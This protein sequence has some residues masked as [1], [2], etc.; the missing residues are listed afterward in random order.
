MSTI[1]AS[2]A[3]N[4][5]SVNGQSVGGALKLDGSYDPAL[6]VAGLDEASYAAA[7]QRMRGAAQGAVTGQVRGSCL[8]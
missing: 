6:G 3:T 8:H 2:R 4:G 1:T 5:C 7:L